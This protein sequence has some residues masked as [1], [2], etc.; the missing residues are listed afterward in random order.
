MTDNQAAGLPH[1]P[2]FA[3]TV[4]KFALLIV[5]AWIGLVV[6][7]SIFVPSLDIV[8]KQHTV[9]MSP[10]AAASMQAMKR[11]GQVFNEFDTDSAIMIVLEGDKPLGDDAHHFYDQLIQKLEADK[12]HVEHVQDFWGDP[13]TAA[14]S[15]SSDGKAAYVQVYLVG[16]QGES[17]ANE[18]V[19]AVRKIVD[20]VPPPPGVKAYVTG[21]A[22]LTADQSAAGEKS[23]IKVTIITF[24]VIIVMLLFV[25]RSIVTVFI[26]LLMVLIELFAARQVVAF[27][28]YNDI[29]GLS[30]FAVFLL[31]LMAI[32]AGT[33]YAIFVLGRY[34]E[35]RS[36]GEDRE[37]AFYT[38]FRGTAHVV[39]GSGLTIAGAMYCLSFTRL[40]YFQTLGVPCAVGM[41]IAV[42]AALTLGPA[43]LTVGSHFGLFD[44]KHRMRT[45]G[46]RRVGTAIVRWPAPILAVSVAIA[47]IGLLALPGYKTNYD[48]RKYLPPYTKANVGYD[49]ADRHFSNA[50]M[51]PELL[52]IETD[53]D[54]RNPAGMLVLDRIARFVFH[55]PGVA[56]VQAI[57]RPL[58]TPI[59]HT[60]IPFQISMQNT[61]QVENQQYMHQRM[62]DMLK[63]ADAMQ[64]S[65][66]TMQRM[67]NITSQMAAVTHH[68]DGLTHEML[69]VT[70]TLRDN[71]ANFDDFWRPIRSYF[72]WE[73]HCYDIPICWSLRSIFDGLDGLDQ[74]TEKFTALSGDISQLD[75]LMPQMLAQ[76]PPMIATMTT[77]KQM[78]L[79]M[80]SSM[81]SLYDQMDV[82]SQNSTAMGQAYDAAKN[83]D[84][85]YIP[86]EVF[87]NPDF[88]RGLKM[89]LS[90]DGHAARFIISHEGDP[91]TPEGISHVD[92]I[93]NAAK[94][95]IKGTPLEGAKIWL[96]GT[97]AVY[98]DMRDG[99][100]YDLM[101]A[102]ISAACL[103]LI[104][105][106]IITRSL[107]AAITIVGTVLIS[108]GASFGLSVLVWQDIMGFELHWM[109]LAMSVILL[110]A[111]G[112][113]YNLLL[114]SRFKEEIHA[115]LKTGIIRSMAG[116]GA[117]VTSAGLVFAATMACFI[118]SDLKVMGQVGTTIGL[119]LLF[120]TLIVR[121]FMMPS[122]A[123]LMGRWFWWP[124]QVRTRPASQLL[125]P[126]GPRPVVRALLLPPENGGTYPNGE[127]PNSATTDRFPAARP[128]Y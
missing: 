112:S 61:T 86:P 115:G 52:L 16:N 102:G 37:Q 85:F 15:Q 78:M 80:H 91:A 26:T 10:Q 128:H 94:E 120:D 12:K 68:M 25:Y 29:I 64:Q 105:M 97:A 92:P 17:K 32:A 70:S 46:W 75:A 28:A 95:A 45:R 110:L 65:I 79:T 109:V 40:P 73:K 121:S 43:V 22:A 48:N 13:L 122:V 63:Q 24:I 51:N 34:Q 124:T 20:S 39:L 89:F 100:K 82:M 96:G 76:M 36:L 27:L 4:H 5:L 55:I 35:A 11:V 31:V 69:D 42:F 88:K 56:R 44:P 21:A 77:M 71:I 18:S 72:Y 2:I 54:M 9:S 103:I 60:S 87:D 107:V 98:K 118:F 74:I 8:A 59:E 66:D 3:R 38:M 114:V 1:M 99:S 127:S 49:A 116:T 90:P 62:N 53:H 101:I 33:D 113:D 93:K 30:I 7:L 23:I 19:R 108:L 84:S 58:G 117:V 41:L 125:R 123:A 83:D 50:R 126:F 106:L 67:Y 111:V 6:V 47:L 14:G 57:T 104:I 119:G 81:S